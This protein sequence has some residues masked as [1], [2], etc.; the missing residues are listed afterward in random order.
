MLIALLEHLGCWPLAHRKTHRI[1]VPILSSNDLEK[2]LSSLGVPAEFLSVARRRY[3]WNIRHLVEDLASS[4]F[5]GR[6]KNIN[7]VKRGIRCHQTF[8]LLER[9]VITFYRQYPCLFP[10]LRWSL[11]HLGDSHSK[12]KLTPGIKRK[13]VVYPGR[14]VEVISPLFIPI[15][16]GRSSPPA[17]RGPRPQRTYR[18][19]PTNCLE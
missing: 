4:K 6:G 17:L 10:S 16:N 9:F 15:N 5:I 14:K 1:A 8:I 3:N 13:E 18:A 11:W 12:K 2:H 7:H 19:R